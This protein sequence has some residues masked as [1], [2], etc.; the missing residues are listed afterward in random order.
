M[1]TA[2]VPVAIVCPPWCEVSPEDHASELW[3][4]EGNCVHRTTSEPIPDTQ[5]SGHSLAEPTFHSPVAVSLTSYGC[6][7]DGRDTDAPTVHL[8]LSGAELGLKQAL[9]LADE[10]RRQVELYRS[11]GGVA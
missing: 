4:Y 3:D 10:I 6:H 7:S 9:A 1:R 11:T 8:H 2:T 5:G